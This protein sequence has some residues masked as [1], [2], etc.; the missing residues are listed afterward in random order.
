MNNKL[1]QLSTVLM[2]FMMVFAGCT[3]NEDMAE[4]IDDTIDDVIY[5]C[6]DNSAI[7][8]DKT[9]QVMT[10]HVTLKEKAKIYSK[11]STP[12]DVIIPTQYTACYHSLQ[13]PF[14]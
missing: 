8:Y 9:Q 1:N 7:N 13:M 14:W 3:G 2:I 5:G 4:I 10:A 11:L 12:T 6:T